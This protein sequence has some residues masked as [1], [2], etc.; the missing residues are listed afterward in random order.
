MSRFT[1]I[2]YIHTCVGVHESMLEI[3]NYITMRY[4]LMYEEVFVKYYCILLFQGEIFF[5]NRKRNIMIIWNTYTND[6]SWIV[7]TRQASNDVR[8]TC[9]EKKRRKRTIIIH[10]WLSFRDNI[11][12]D[13]CM[14]LIESKILRTLFMWVVFIVWRGNCSNEFEFF[15]FCISSIF[16]NKHWW[17]LI[18]T[19]K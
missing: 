9:N 7:M 18:Q 1:I 10:E 15:F 6:W 12:G 11:F 8:L 16:T 13:F 2:S 4:T 17:S 5:E 14:F 19:V 3:Q